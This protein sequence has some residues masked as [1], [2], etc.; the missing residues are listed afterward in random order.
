MTKKTVNSNLTFLRW[1]Y[2]ITGEL[3]EF[4]LSQLNHFGNN[5]AMFSQL[6][7]IITLLAILANK[8]GIACLLLLVALTVISIRQDVLIRKLGLDRLEIDRS[9]LKMARQQMFRRTCYQTLTVFFLT[10]PMLAFLW[11]IQTPDSTISI[12]EFLTLFSP[13]VITSICVMSFIFFYFVNRRKIT[14]ID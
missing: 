4:T 10:L 14:I 12:Q 1:F 8:A 13:L 6:T 9:E 11:Q 2:N 3:D 5:V 7:M